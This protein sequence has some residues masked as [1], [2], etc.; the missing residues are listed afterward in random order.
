MS[1]F[2]DQGPGRVRGGDLQPQAPG[3]HAGQ[4]SG[5]QVGGRLDTG[6]GDRGTERFQDAGSWCNDDQAI[7]GHLGRAGDL[8]VALQV[9]VHRRS[10]SHA[11]TRAVQY[12]HLS[13]TGPYQCSDHNQQHGPADHDAKIGGHTGS[14]DSPYLRRIAVWTC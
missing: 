3:V 12:G 5:V 14:R 2:H 13:G 7:V 4:G 6:T 9:Q 10:G 1:A 11:E 8:E